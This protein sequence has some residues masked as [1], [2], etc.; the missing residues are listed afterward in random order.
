MTDTLTTLLTT[1]LGGASVIL[2]L[3]V[4]SRSTRARYGAKWRCWAWLLLCLRLAVPFP[5]LPQIDRTEP[6]LIQ[7]PAPSDTIIY[8]APAAQPDS[9][10]DTAPAPT[11]PSPRPQ[12]TQPTVETP[13]EPFTLSLTQLVMLVWLAGVAVFVL[14]TLGQ[15]LR[16]LAYLRRWSR[17]VAE[18]NILDLF[19]Q[20]CD[21]LHL[22][23][24]PQLRYCQ[25]LNIPMLAGIFRPIL[26]LPEETCSPEA[27]RYSLLHELTHFRRKDIWL[28]ALAL[29]VNAVHWFNPAVWYMVRLVERDTELACDEAALLTLPSAEHAA[30]GRT[31]LNAAD[32]LSK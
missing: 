31:I 11:I 27:L 17:P 6:S 19:Q 22:R 25:G 15:H 28:K 26:L 14:W 18:A 32:R 3:A 1:T 30:Y 13:S 23:R 2:L 4:A 12:I 20:L 21:Q 24:P 16:F 7:L 8:Q 10:A 29:W 9:S 5:L